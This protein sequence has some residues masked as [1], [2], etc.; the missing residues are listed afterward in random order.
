[1]KKQISG[2]KNLLCMNDS[3]KILRKMTKPVSC[4]LNFTYTCSIIFDISTLVH[5]KR[6][7]YT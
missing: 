6:P 3:L 4:K 2:E 7:E 5:N 1:M